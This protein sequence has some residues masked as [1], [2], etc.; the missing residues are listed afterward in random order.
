LLIDTSTGSDGGSEQDGLTRRL[1]EIPEHSHFDGRAGSAGDLCYV[2]D[3]TGHLTMASHEKSL[4]PDLGLLLPPATEYRLMADGPAALKLDVVSLPA[5]AGHAQATS[6][7]M[8]RA[9]HE[10]EV[11]TTGDREFRVLFG[12]GFGC[13]LATQFVGDIPPG[14]A[15]DHRHPYDEVV[16]VLSG[17]GI[18]HVGGKD[19]RVSAG[20]CLHLRP[21]QPHCMENAGTTT[22]RVLGVFHPA[23]SPA[24]KLS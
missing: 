18:A 1:I 15:P 6:V 17:E 9:L 22:M 19:H 2:L 24:A 23:D 10:C 14:R 5:Q 21:G 11:E 20:S 16:L 12:P 4:R 7:P 8:V 13:D 3:G